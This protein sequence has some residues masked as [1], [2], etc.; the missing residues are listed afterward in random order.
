MESA[1]S[2]FFG[3]RNV[4]LLDEDSF[5]KNARIIVKDDRI[6][7]AGEDTQVPTHIPN[8][9]EWL[10][11]EGCWI[12]PGFVNAHTHVA[13]S[14]LREL[15]HPSKN[16]IHDIFFPTESQLEAHDVYTFGFPSL[17]SGLMSGVTTF[18]DHYYFSN[19]VGRAA[20]ELGVRAYVA[21]TLAD[22]GGPKRIKEKIEDYVCP[23]NWNGNSSDLIQNI[24]GPH[25]TDTVSP[26][27]LKEFALWHRHWGT[28]LHMHLSQTKTEFEYIQKKYHMTPTALAQSLGVLTPNSLCV[29][30]VSA[31]QADF[32]ILKS[33]G[34]FVGLCPSSQIIYEQLAP[35]NWIHEAEVPCVIGT[36]CAASHDSMDFMQELRTCYLSFRTKGCQVSAQEILKMAWTNPAKWLKAPLGSLSPGSFADL[37]FFERD[38]ACEPMNDPHLHL[39]M[40]MSSR[41]VKDVMVAGKWTLKDR[42][43]DLPNAKELQHS[44]DS[45]FRR[46]KSFIKK[47]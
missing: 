9:Q 8:P 1:S 25:A 23:T 2:A 32:K 46:M 29:H 18:V 43:I 3:I 24:L 15:T 11:G 35:L 28:P 44:L 33:S 12:T 5:V 20:K 19:E 27:Y 31:N 39:I 13:M 21:E 14:F 38:L 4:S 37:V 16:M 42:K 17:V 47:A 45:R 36:D 22:I 7:W 26:E 10:D 30:L 41:H 6:L 40:S 34:A